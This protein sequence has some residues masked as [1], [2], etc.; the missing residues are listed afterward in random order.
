MNALLQVTKNCENIGNWWYEHWKIEHYWNGQPIQSRL[1]QGLSATK[2]SAVSWHDAT[3]GAEQ[4][5]E[6]R[7]SQVGSRKEHHVPKPPSSFRPAAITKQFT[8][9]L[10]HLY[11][12]N[13]WNSLTSSSC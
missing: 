2:R 6:R 9:T 13:A 12:L 3:V 4:K 8:I 11:Q 1:L 10:N 7:Y 5:N